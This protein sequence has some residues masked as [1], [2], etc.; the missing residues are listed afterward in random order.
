MDLPGHFTGIG[1]GA[2]QKD[3][4]L[5]LQCQ[6]FVVHITFPGRFGFIRRTVPVHVSTHNTH[7]A[8]SRS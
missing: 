7:R 6:E 4:Q 5:P 3:G 1:S 2:A 8:L